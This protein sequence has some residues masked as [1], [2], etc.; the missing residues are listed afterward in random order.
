[1][2]KKIIMIKN[3]MLRDDSDL[4]VFSKLEH[5]LILDRKRVGKNFQDELKTIKLYIDI[6]GNKNKEKNISKHILYLKQK[7]EN[8]DE[9]CMLMQRGH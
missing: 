7:V 9:K 3:S 1:M 6:I 8:L 2:I 4:S 5:I